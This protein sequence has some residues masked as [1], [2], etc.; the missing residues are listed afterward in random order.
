MVTVH[1]L[2]NAHWQVG[3]LPETGA[4]IAYGRIRYSGNWLDILRPTDEAN[5]GNS[6][7]SSSF[8]ML[9]WANRIKDAKFSFEGK[10]YQLE[11]TPDDGTA[12]HGDVRKRPWQVDE[13]DEDHIRLSVQVPDANF[14]FPFSAQVEYR[15]DD[16]DFI[17]SLRL[18]NE[19]QQSMPGGFGFHPYFVRTDGDN[20]PQLQIPC[21][22]YFEL[23]NSLATDA[24]IPIIP[25]LDYRNLRKLDDEIYDNVLTGRINDDPVR[26]VYPAWEKEIRLYADVLY[27]HFLLFTPANEPSFAIEP[28]TNTNDGFNLYADGVDGTGVFVLVAGEAQQAAV[29]LQVT[30]FG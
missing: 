27:Q 8:I 24:P 2:Q 18:K 11:A 6:S 25:K 4:S 1:Q 17:W 20:T 9:P 10:T 16:T 7:K 28:Q 21:Q 12:R 19:S 14:P 3:I 15:L 29:R 13:A 26:M 30:D 23:T 22:Q 5:Y